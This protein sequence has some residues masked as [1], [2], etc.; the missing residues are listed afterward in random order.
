MK[1]EKQ[2]VNI[3]SV[4]GGRHDVRSSLVWIC[5]GSLI[6]VSCAEERLDA[7][8]VAAS[9]A[10]TPVVQRVH[11]PAGAGA[12]EPHLFA[13]KDSVLLSWL[14][15]VVGTD[16]TALR[17]SRYK[18][19]H[20]SQPR[21]IVDRSDL[22]VNWA[23][24]PSLAEDEKG[25]LFA[26][27]LQKNGTG[28]Y[29]YDVRMAISSDGGVTWGKSFV[30]NRDGKQA[31]HGFATLVPLPGGGVGATW[32]DGRNMKAGGHDGGDHETGGDMTLRY[33]TIDARGT[34]AA[35]VPLDERTCECCTT[36]MAMT[37]AGP[38]IVYRDRTA[39]EVRDVSVVNRQA[40]G[41]SQPRTLHADGWKIDGCPVNGPQIDALGDRVAVAWFTAAGDKQRAYVALS[42]DSGAKF[43]KPIVIDDGKPAGRT[44]IVVLSRE[45]ALVTWL[46]QTPAGA[47]IRARR[48]HFNGKAGPSWKVAD[49]AAA[50]AAGFARMA[51]SGKE[52]FIAWT[53]QSATSKRIHVARF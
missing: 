9:V 6:A 5:A 26:H 16:R 47:E 29:A 50:R 27:W 42:N 41:W 7:Q 10:A 38:V 17:F 46:E 39:D 32:L 51:R 2:F 8:Q 1:I 19:G 52:V 24:F 11:S 49:S 23:D 18:G 12:A 21:V 20:W 34:I 53:E 30:L 28:P 22:F 14:E 36:G 3:E 31:E 33:A 48:V 35:D 13:A 25:V 15:P 37:A 40:K 45:E 4:V 44:D 43:G